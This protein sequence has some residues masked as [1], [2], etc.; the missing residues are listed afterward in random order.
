[1][2][3]AAVAGGLGGAGPGS[4]ADCRDP[5][6]VAAPGELDPTFG[7]F[8]RGK[9]IVD[10]GG[11]D[12]ATSVV[13]REDCTIVAAGE[14]RASPGAAAFGLARVQADGAL[15]RRFGGDG[16]V[17]TAVGRLHDRAEAVA[18]LPGG[19]VVAAGWS[20][21]EPGSHDSVVVRYRADGSLRTS[22]ARDGVFR[23]RLGGNDR[24]HAVLTTDRR[25]VVAGSH[26]GRIVVFALRHGGGF[27]LS[28][29]GFGTLFGLRRGPGIAYAL[30]PAPGGR[31][32]VAGSSGDGDLVVL[33]L[34]ASGRPDDDFGG[35]GRVEVAA[36][37]LERAFSV[38]AQRDGRVLV[39]G[40]QGDPGRTAVVVARLLADGSRDRSFDGDGVL[41]RRDIG[42]FARGLFVTPHLRSHVLVAGG[43]QIESGAGR[44][45]ALRLRA[46]GRP[47]PIWGANGIQLTD[48]RRIVV[49]DGQEISGPGDP[50]ALGF[51]GVLQRNARLVL[52][53]QT[54]AGPSGNLDFGIVRL[55]R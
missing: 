37:G 7:T 34:T 1:L 8:S 17:R 55:A 32:L 26:A 31:L 5:T 2:A 4:D 30:A 16:T 49:H 3:L 54:G 24:V 28:F 46:D 42:T 38:A 20:L 15:D 53:G 33:R 44:F 47:E 51:A 40:T 45:L 12:V 41:L 21:V 25:I 13:V 14:T 35:D 52:A 6:R 39:T 19:D 50:R 10:L 48:L 23:S 9:T 36:G 29:G 11:D 18:E 27:D 22:F 43:A